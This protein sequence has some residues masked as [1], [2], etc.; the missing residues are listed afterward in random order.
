MC[1]S[2]E[3]PRNLIYESAQ[4]LLILFSGIPFISIYLFT[5]VKFKFRSDDYIFSFL[6]VK[7]Y[8]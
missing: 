3:I 5:K 6:C 8:N 2:I 1:A 7:R 4:L